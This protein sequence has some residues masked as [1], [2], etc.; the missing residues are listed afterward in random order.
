[1]SVIDMAAKDRA[2][3]RVS[4]VLGSAAVKLLS[5]DPREAAL[6]AHDVR[7]WGPSATELEARIRQFQADHG[8]TSHAA[9]GKAEGEAA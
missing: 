3:N 4:S 5:S 8:V 6:R 9:S 7:P 2:I 1:M